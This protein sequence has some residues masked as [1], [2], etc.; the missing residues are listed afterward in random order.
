MSIAPSTTQP[1]LTEPVTRTFG[2][3]TLSVQQSIEGRYVLTAFIGAVKHSSLSFDTA[4]WRNL[5]TR[6]AFI[7][8]RALDGM[9]V[10]DIAAL[11]HRQ[12]I[13]NEFEVARRRNDKPRMAQLEAADIAEMDDEEK[14]F[15]ADVRNHVAEVAGINAE[16]A[17]DRR[18]AQRRNVQDIL[19][20]STYSPY[21]GFRKGGNN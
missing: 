16:V 13:R 1:I 20:N 17:R 9:H 19:T 7:A 18:H 12:N 21:R 2:V 15:A 14:A 6:I 4:D 3:V 11:I 10:D 5:Q 8:E